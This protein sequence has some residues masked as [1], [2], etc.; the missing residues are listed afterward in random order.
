MASY[1]FVM[2]IH[3][4]AIVISTNSEFRRNIRKST[5]E[6]SRLLDKDVIDEIKKQKK[7]TMTQANSNQIYQYSEKQ[8]PNAN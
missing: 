8:E 7:Q 3:S 6:Q 1:F 4:S 5:I 2:G